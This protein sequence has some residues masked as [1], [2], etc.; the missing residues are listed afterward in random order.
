MF[1]TLLR[2]YT[3]DDPHWWQVYLLLVHSKVGPPGREGLE[4]HGLLREVDLIHVHEP[5]L[6]FLSV[7]DTLKQLRLH[8][9]VP[10]GFVHRQRLQLPHCLAPN[11]VC[12]VEPA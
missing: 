5:A 12:V 10:A 4:Q 11:A 6:V 2:G 8:L 3:S 1:Y 7:N 9:L